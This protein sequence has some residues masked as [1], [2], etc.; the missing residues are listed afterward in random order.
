MCWNL[1]KFTTLSIGVL[2]IQL[3]SKVHFR[4]SYTLAHCTMF[5]AK[6][7]FIKTTIVVKYYE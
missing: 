1:V 5:V 2:L 6:E 4:V 3:V 7:L